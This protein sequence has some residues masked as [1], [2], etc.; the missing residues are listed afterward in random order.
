MRVPPFFD[1]FVLYIL[2]YRGSTAAAAV[3]TRVYSIRTSYR[4]SSDLHSHGIQH[5][6]PVVSV[7]HLSGG[8]IHSRQWDATTVV[9]APTGRF[10]HVVYGSRRVGVQQQQVSRA[11][12]G[13]IERCIVRSRIW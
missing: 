8:G 1:F 2:L 9:D 13:Y 12:S 5:L 11:L 4:Y 6:D 3:C 10:P 7:R